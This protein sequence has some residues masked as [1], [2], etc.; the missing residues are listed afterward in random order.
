[1]RSVVDLLVCHLPNS[2]LFVVASLASPS[3][4]WTLRTARNTFTTMN[5]RAKA[6]PTVSTCMRAAVVAAAAVLIAV[7]LCTR[8][9]HQPSVAAALAKITYSSGVKL[10]AA[11]L[12]PQRARLTVSCDDCNKPR[13]LFAVKRLT[14]E[15]NLQLQRLLD[16]L[17]F[18]C[19]SPV[20]P[21]GHELWGVV[22]SNEK[23]LCA[24]DVCSAYYD[25]AERLS[26]KDVCVHCGSAENL[27]DVTELRKQHT[28]V[29]PCC[30]APACAL[31]GPVTSCAAAKRSLL[32][33]PC[34]CVVLHALM[35]E[36]L[37]WCM[38]RARQATKES[39]CSSA[40]AQESSSQPC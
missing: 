21:E 5:S 7:V 17:H 1:M 10:N 33:D 25:S 28:K 11:A 4:S 31:L 8:T 26:F 15:Q 29:R 39:S 27:I 19:G 22:Y 13:C 20:V 36:C 24:A 2:L 30:S 9:E 16:D 34:S 12:A 6:L 35:I 40:Q 18:T 32:I 23:L 37:C 3:H 14:A 38:F